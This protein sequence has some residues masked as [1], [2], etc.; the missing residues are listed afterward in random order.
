MNT[1]KVQEIIASKKRGQPI[2]IITSDYSYWG[3]LYDYQSPVVTLKPYY[4]NKFED[5]HLDE[6]PKE[7]S[8]TDIIDIH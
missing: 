5:L 7:I 2:E 8:L 3:R 6:R 4:T 1:I